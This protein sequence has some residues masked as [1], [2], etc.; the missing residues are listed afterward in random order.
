MKQKIRWLDYDRLTQIALFLVLTACFSYTFP[1]WQDPNQNSHIDMILAVVEQGTFQIDRYVQNTVDYARV[2]SH[3]Y[4]DKAPGISFLGIPVYAGLRFFLNLPLMDRLMTRLEGNGAFVATLRQNG[5]GILEDK[6]RFA[7]AQ[8]ALTFVL[9]VLPSALLGVLIYLL[10]G[11]FTR[12]LV[13]RAGL[14]LAYGLLTPAFAYAGS[15]YSHQLS[16][17][18]LFGAFYLIFSRGRQ[19]GAVILLAIGLM[20][21]YSVISEY[22]SIILVGILFVYT[23]YVLF[24]RDDW[25]KIGWVILPAGLIALGLM[26]YNNAIFGGPFKLGYSFSEDWTV[27]HHTGFMSLTFPHPEALWG[28]TFGVF[29]GLFILSPWLLFCVPGLVLWWRSRE[30]RPEFW[31]VLGGILG[32]FWF[33]ASSVMW[34]GGFAVGPRYLLPMLPFMVLPVVYVYRAWGGKTWLWGVGAVLY[35]WSFIATWGMTLSEQAFPPDTIANPFLDFV[36][37]NWQSG[38]I[39]RNLGTILGI[40]G[41]WSLVPLLIVGAAIILGWWLFTNR[42]GSTPVYRPGFSR[43]QADSR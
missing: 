31:V 4:S 10:L 8:V 38:N 16:A 18:L 27:Q 12:S 23:C 41:A 30:H 26:A 5:S 36:L 22:P 19:F 24:R 42:P 11:R 28:I 9:A 2:G 15:F 1:R 37:P 17:L 3:Y 25:R 40:H 32:F 43:Q 33:N 21:G 34:W 35:L 39:A 6:V 14:V 7:V 13:I 29:R 20:L